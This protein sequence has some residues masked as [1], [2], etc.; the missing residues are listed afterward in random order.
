[1]PR[2]TPRNGDDELLLARISEAAGR[3][4][5][6]RRHATF[7]GLAHRSCPA[8]MRI[9]AIREAQRAATRLD[10]YEHGMTVA[11][12]GRIHVVRYDS[13]SVFR[14]YAS[15][16]DHHLETYA[17]TDVHG[18]QVAL[19]GRPERGLTRI[20]SCGGFHDAEVW[21]PEIQRAVTEAQLPR[22]MAALGKGEQL[23]F[24]DIWL[25]KEKVGSGQVSARWPLVERIEIH[26]GSV[27][28]NIAGKW[29][30]LGTVVSEVPNF[31]VLRALVEH[32]RTDGAC[33]P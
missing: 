21:Q 16:Q 27:E 4:R 9:L 32:L 13:T 23:A 28:L 26:N 30:G 11:V 25:T 29:H 7:P 1:M 18:Q 15:H 6:G 3:E 22:A 5:I 10:L 31:F 33:P 20:A 19:C 14:A 12:N 8:V 2:K 24:G 17:V